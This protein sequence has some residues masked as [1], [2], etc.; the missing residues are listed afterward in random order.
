MLPA[1]VIERWTGGSVDLP[2]ELVEDSN[3]YTIL[4]GAAAKTVAERFTGLA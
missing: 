3:H 2:A 4:L 1:T